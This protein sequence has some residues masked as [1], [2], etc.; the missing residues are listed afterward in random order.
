MTIMSPRLHMTAITTI[1]ITI[2]IRR[3]IACGWGVGRPYPKSK[4]GRFFDSWS[5]IMRLSLR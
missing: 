1:P 2:A 4:A 5:E 3:G